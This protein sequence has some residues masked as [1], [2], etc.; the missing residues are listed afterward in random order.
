MDAGQYKRMTQWLRKQLFGRDEDER[1]VRL[2]IRHADVSGKVGSEIDS[3]TIDPK[4]TDN[5][6]DGIAIEIQNACLADADGTR[7]A[8][9][10][11]MVYS[12]NAEKR[13]VAR[14]PINYQSESDFEEGSES[15]TEP[16]SKSGLVS[17]AMRHVEAIMKL[18]VGSTTHTISMLNRTIKDQQDQILSMQGKHMEYI[19]LVENLSSLKHERDL[20]ARQADAK[21]EAMKEVGAKV[22]MLLP[23]IVNRISGKKMLPETTTPIEVML[24]EL[25]DGMSADQLGALQGILKPEQQIVIFE[26][27]QKVKEKREA[28]AAGKNGKSS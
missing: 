17:Q 15:R 22:A 5:D 28:A 27:I 10:R 21:L 25:M 26:F 19:A 7:E 16:A 2:V 1:C 23:S 14:I 18:N 6:V 8:M 9:Q 13:Q 11:Y 12:F 24:E 3:V 4:V 20:A